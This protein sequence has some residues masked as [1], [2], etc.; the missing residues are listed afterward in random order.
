M[1]ILRLAHT[2]R[3]VCPQM[4]SLPGLRPAYPPP[5]ALAAEIATAIA[6]YLVSYDWQPP[7][8]LPQPSTL[9]AACRAMAND[10]PEASKFPVRVPEHCAV[11]LVRGSSQSLENLPC[12]PMARLKAPWPIPADCSCTSSSIPADAQLLRTTPL[13]VN[14]GTTPHAKELPL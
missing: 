11:I 7:G 2:C 12:A 5:L 3:G 14:R 8:A 10:Q 4:V 1:V 13:S 6:R 9:L